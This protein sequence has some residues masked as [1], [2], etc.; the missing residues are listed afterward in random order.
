VTTRRLGVILAAVAVLG[1]V[2]AV[3]SMR[4]LPTTTST[5]D[6]ALLELYTMHAADGDLRVGPYSRFQWNHPGPIYLY[7]AAPLFALSGQR[8]FGLHPT[9]LLINIAALAAFIFIVARF[10]GA[11]LGWSAIAALALFLFRSAPFPGRAISQLLISPWNPHVVILPFA[12]LIALCAVLAAGR[13]LVLPAIALVGSFI[14]QTHIGLLPCTVAVVTVA[15]VLWFLGDRVRPG[16]AIATDDRA[17]TSHR[18]WLLA[19]GGVLLVLW[20]L[21]LADQVAGTG[22]AGEIVRFLLSD[23]R[24]RPSLATSL[25]ALAYG[26]SGAVRPDQR[27][28]IGNVTVVGGEMGPVPAAWPVLLLVLLALAWR[29]AVRQGRP[30]HAALCLLCLV[31]T[32]AAGWSVFNVR[33]VMRDY[34][35]LWVSMLGTVSLAA[36]GGVVAWWVGRVLT[37]RRFELPAGFGPVSMMAFV[38]V[39]FLLGAGSL[40]LEYRRTLAGQGSSPRQRE[41]VADL[42]HEVEDHLRARGYRSARIRVAPSVWGIAASVVLQLHKT[43]IAVAVPDPLLPM[44]TGAL[45]STGEEQVVLRFVGPALDGELRGQPRYSLITESRGVVGPV[46]AL[47]PAVSVYEQRPPGPPGGRDR[48]SEMSREEGDP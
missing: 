26:L 21:P 23:D 34:L 37:S 22:N 46:N 48:R 31:T 42:F 10:G 8:E 39:V 27:L 29:W 20:M 3:A 5:G 36:L 15:L 47:T 41:I 43:D 24:P 19:A 9:A 2:L 35:I 6:R 32:L 1:L 14:V 38:L 18:P 11:A 45:R 17:A 40:G 7:A 25:T 13:S 30:F 12:L 4:L 33:G 44:F 16:P 28:A